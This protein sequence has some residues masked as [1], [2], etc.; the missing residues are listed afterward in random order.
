[1]TPQQRASI[2][3]IFDEAL[4]LAG[5]ERETYLL[6]ACAGNQE[7]YREVKSLLG[8]SC[9]TADFLQHSAL[10]LATH[11][12]AQ[13]L[14]PLQP[15]ARLGRYEILHELGHGGM[16]DVFHARDDIGLSVAIKVL[17]DYFAQDPERVSRF[18]SEARKMA[19]L[20]HPNIAGIHGREVTGGWRFLVLEYVAGETLEARLAQGAMPV[21]EA[22][23]VFA[24]IADA[25]AATH[26][27]DI[28]H[29]DLKPSNIMLTPQQQVKLLDF[30][31]AKHFHHLEAS[32]TTA[33]VRSQRVTM[34]QS[35]TLPG[36]TPGTLPYM[37]PEQRMG[38]TTDHTTDL[39]AF[40]VVFYEALTGQNP[41][42]RDTREDT[43][44]AIANFTPEWKRLP[45][46]TP[47]SIRTL[48]Q[49][50]LT[51]DPAARLQDAG[52]AKAIIA[53]ELADRFALPA[54][55]EQFP[56]YFTRPV[57]IGLACVAALVIAYLGWRYYQNQFL[58]LAVV[59]PAT[60]TCTPLNA[61][62]LTAQL[63]RLSRVRASQ[64]STSQNLTLQLTCAD[65]GNATL[66]QLVNAQGITMFAH[67]AAN[68]AQ[69]L[70][71]LQPVL[72]ALATRSGA[73][74]SALNAQ[75]NLVAPSLTN[76]RPEE[77]NILN[78]DQWDNEAMLNSAIDLVKKLIAEKGNSATLQAALSR[79]HLFKF[80]LTQLPAERQQAYDAYT[81]ALT[82]EPDSAAA[83]IAAGNYYNVAGEAKA[84]QYFQDA[85]QR[86]P[87]NAE[88]TDAAEAY[89]GLARAHEIAKEFDQAEANFIASLLA[90]PNY[91]GGYNELGAF[92]LGQQQ[93]QLAQV[94]FTS[95]TRLFDTPVAHTNLG[96][97]YY[98][99]DRFAEAFAAYE[100]ALK[101]SPRAETYINCGLLRYQENNYSQALE[102][103]KSATEKAPQM[104]EAWG[105]LGQALYAQE[106][107][108]AASQAALQ[109]A[110]Q[111]ATS[112]LQ[113]N[114]DPTD[115][116]MMTALKALWQALLSQPAPALQAIQSVLP[117]PNSNDL[118]AHL[119]I[120]E[121]A[122]V[123][124]HVVGHDD[125]ALAW[126]ERFL[127][128]GGKAASLARE[129]LLAALRTD[130]RYPRLVAP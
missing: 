128:H 13:E 116:A 12:L 114:I 11:A 102:Y 22:L 101:R 129:P 31:I 8:E 44:T 54:W 62:A 20:Q 86:R 14:T 40:G 82:M 41:F 27:K 26:R 36:F 48:L 5:N 75:L 125:T 74:S 16:G 67:Q 37:S 39:W 112:Q 110:V 70:A 69:A 60:A 117:T 25:L 47:H 115:K 45:R 81:L 52:E 77:Q 51:K 29:R 32:V 56:R 9:Q 98:L 97:A 28:V 91:W 34:S 2:P 108:S 42:R 84:K 33:E 61:A 46:E 100:N 95:A 38:A 30:G 71:R 122:I 78:L 6:R 63:N 94:Y 50:C 105:Y 15:G 107:R 123:I 118:S 7:L 96:N 109:Q 87:A 93:F 18:E 79:A 24:Q 119:D 121:Q 68:E 43:T 92:Y 23:S 83:M 53:A 85:L 113:N 88:A 104:P 57:T 4:E 35:L 10:S 3:D 19:Q 89:R 66:L 72:A 126:V 59:A 80:R 106:P 21:R 127:Q 124:F 17:P 120:I 64:A 99:Q 58:R 65:A 73:Q 111:L 76:L 1:M 130:P 103:F 55:L 90:R 49:R